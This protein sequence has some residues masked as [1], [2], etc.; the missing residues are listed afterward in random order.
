MS[1]ESEP[2]SVRNLVTASLAKSM[3]A[4]ICLLLEP[5]NPDGVIQVRS[6][7]NRHQNQYLGSATLEGGFG[8]H[9]DICLQDGARPSFILPE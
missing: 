6:A 1:A 7:Y 3:Q 5:P 8:S 4:D 2:E 9:A